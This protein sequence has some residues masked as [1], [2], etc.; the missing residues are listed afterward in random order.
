M[1]ERRGVKLPSL[2]LSHP[3]LP[4][5]VPAFACSPIASP[6]QCFIKLCELC[7]SDI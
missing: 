3:P 5:V 6:A 4:L 2:R 7:Q 1:K